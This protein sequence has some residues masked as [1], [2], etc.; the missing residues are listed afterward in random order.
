MVIW[1]PGRYPAGVA[2]HGGRVLPQPEMRLSAH[3][4][5]RDTYIHDRVDV[6]NHLGF[7]CVVQPENLTAPLFA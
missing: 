1:Q 4:P 7:R 5:G 6:E 2:G 3:D